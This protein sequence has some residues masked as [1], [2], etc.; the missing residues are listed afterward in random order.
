M[1]QPVIALRGAMGTV[2]AAMLPPLVPYIPPLARETERCPCGGSGLL[3]EESMCRPCRSRAVSV[4]GQRLTR[5]I[6]AIQYDHRDVRLTW[7]EASEH[8][9][10]FTPRIDFLMP[11]VHNPQGPPHRFRA[12]AFWED[13]LLISACARGASDEEIV[14]LA[15]SMAH[16]ALATQAL[17]DIGEWYT[18]RSSQVY[19]PHRPDPYLPHDEDC[20]PDGNG[21]VILWLAY[22]SPAC[23][24]AGHPQGDTP[25]R[26][27]R[28]TR[29]PVDRQD[30]G[31]MPGQTLLLGTGR[32]TV[33]A[34]ASNIRTDGDWTVRRDGEGALAA[35][36]RDVHQ[37][38]AMSELEVVARNLHLDGHPAFDP[39]PACLR[40]AP[41]GG[42]F[43]DAYLTYDG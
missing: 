28:A 38:M 7:T 2:E 24:E 14:A 41:A 15:L 11:D 31:T 35:A 37:T 21:P 19:P 4:H 40:P 39:I 13:D 26:P 36:L 16:Y 3:C 42:L 9:S 6:S 8:A 1:L 29:P 10:A 23:A 25:M 27:M 5:L 30:L 32:V 20:G 12:F 18:Y 33:T 17:H 43:W 34:P 22:G